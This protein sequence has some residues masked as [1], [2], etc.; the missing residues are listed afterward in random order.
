MGKRSTRRRSDTPKPGVT[1]TLW[2]GAACHNASYPMTYAREQIGELAF[3]RDGHFSE[4]ELTQL[5]SLL[6]GLVYPLRTA[7]IYRTASR[8]ALRDPLTIPVVGQRA[9]RRMPAARGAATH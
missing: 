4:Q 8:S 2:E 7:L 5:E 6:T 9:G 1:L 3:Q